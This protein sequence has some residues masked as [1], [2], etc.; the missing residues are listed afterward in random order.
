MSYFGQG[1]G[2]KKVKGIGKGL[3]KI[4]VGGKRKTAAEKEEEEKAFNK[5]AH[6]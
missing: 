3:G 6:F 2:L 4:L 5:R 1:K